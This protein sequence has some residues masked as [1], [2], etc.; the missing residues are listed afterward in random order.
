LRGGGENEEGGGRE[1][2]G[3]YGFEKDEKNTANMR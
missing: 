3:I 1:E 2:K